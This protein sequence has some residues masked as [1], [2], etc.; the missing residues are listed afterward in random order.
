MGIG[1][2]VMNIRINIYSLKK[3]VPRCGCVCNLRFKGLPVSLS[4]GWWLRSFLKV[5]IFYLCLLYFSYKHVGVHFCVCWL[6][7]KTTPLH[8]ETLRPLHLPDLSVISRTKSMVYIFVI[9]Y[10]L[11]CIYIHI[12]SSYKYKRYFYGSIMYKYSA[13]MAGAGWPQ[14][15]RTL[16]LII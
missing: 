1:F 8:C 3:S 5:H 13:P 7:S 11:F 12:Y 14:V 16:Q 10:L 15:L 2:F 6:G 4:G 9:L